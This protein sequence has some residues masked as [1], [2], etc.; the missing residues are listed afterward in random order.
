MIWVTLIRDRIISRVWGIHGKTF[1]AGGVAVVTLAF[2]PT[3]GITA[4]DGSSLAVN[5]GSTS[6]DGSLTLTFTTNEVTTDFVDGDITV[7][8]GTLSNFSGSGN[9]YTAT[10]TPTSDGLVT[11]DVASGVFTGSSGLTNK[12]STQFTWTYDGTAPTLSPVGIVSNN[13]LDTSLAKVGDVVTLSFTS[14]EVV[15]TPTVTIAGQ[16]ATVTNTS[17]NDWTATYTMTSNETEGAISFSIAFDDAAGNAGTA[18][19][20]VTDSSS[21]NFDNTAPTV[22]SIVTD[23]KVK[24]EDVVRVTTTFSEAMTASPTISIDLPNGTDISAESMT[25]S[26][27]A[28][29]WYYAWTVSDG[30]DGTATITVAG[31]DLAGNAY[32]GTDTDT[33]TIDNT[34]PTVSIHSYR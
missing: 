2:S 10:L 22:V 5:S 18:V 33:V 9:T 34:A 14:S 1:D 26:T 24:D 23:D 25:Q 31:S 12:A 20:A 19:T 3:V 6:N 27:T 16:S 17:S 13:N 21:V 30:G 32:T 29:V 7:V 28:D 8:N 4:V 15:G 11:L